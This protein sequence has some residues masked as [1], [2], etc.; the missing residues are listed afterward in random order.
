MRCACAATE[1]PFDSDSLD[2]VLM[3]HV[4]EF[5]E[6]PHQIIREVE[7]VLMTGRQSD[8]QRLQSV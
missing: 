5:A 3:P 7:R 6:S 1:L 8:H 4:L 2:L